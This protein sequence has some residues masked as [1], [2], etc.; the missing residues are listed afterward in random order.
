M[1]T[2]RYSSESISDFFYAVDYL[3][4]VCVNMSMLEEIN[5]TAED[6]KEIN[7]IPGR[8]I[9]FSPALVTGVFSLSQFHYSS[10]TNFLSLMLFNN[11]DETFIE[12]SFPFLMVNLTEPLYAED[13][14]KP[15]NGCNL[16][17]NWGHFV[18]ASTRNILINYGL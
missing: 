11:I 7:D 10:D 13:I 5:C 2:K 3:M 4:T 17:P 15:E 16:K 9:H 1:Q 12:Q 8:T 6:L 14:C 18:A